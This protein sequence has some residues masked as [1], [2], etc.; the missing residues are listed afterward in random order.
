MNKCYFILYDNNGD[1]K[2]VR[3]KHNTAAALKLAQNHLQ[4]NPHEKIK[5]IYKKRIRL[6]CSLQYGSHA[7]ETFFTGRENFACDIIMNQILLQ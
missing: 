4:I 7:K 2:V 5:V 6:T 3:R 1:G